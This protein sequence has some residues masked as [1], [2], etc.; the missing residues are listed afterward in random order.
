MRRIWSVVLSAVA[1]VLAGT[2]VGADGP[3]AAAADASRFAG[4]YFAPLNSVIWR[5]RLPDGRFQSFERLLNTPGSFRSPGGWQARQE[6][7]RIA[8]FAPE[9]P[10][11]PAARYEFDRGLLVRYVSAGVTNDFDRASWNWTLPAGLSPLLD[12]TEVKRTDPGEIEM[13]EERKW[14]KSGRLRF[15]YANPN[16]SGLLYA[17]L[18]LLAFGWAASRLRGR[19]IG[20]AAGAV[21]FGMLLATGSRGALLGFVV[22]LA[23]ML[24][25]RFKSSLRSRRFWL[26][27]AAVLCAAAA[28]L[29]V[30]R[31]RMLT[32][33]FGEGR[34]G[35]SNRIRL[36]L[37]SAAPKMM[38]DAPD[39]WGF[40]G[41]G[42]AYVNWYQPYEKVCFTGT[43]MN[44]HLN[45]LVEYGWTGRALYLWGGFALLCLLAFS[46]R[47]IGTVAPLSVWLAVATASWFNPVTR[48]VDAFIV[49]VLGL[50]PLAVRWRRWLSVWRVLAA[51]GAGAVLAGLALG[52]IVLL[53]S[54]AAAERPSVR[55][56]AGRVLLG[57]RAPE[58]WVVDD[59][60]ALGGILF[61]KDMRAMYRAND[62]LPPVG[63]VDDVATVPESAQRL[64]LAGGAGDDWLRRV[65][66]DEKARARLPR[67]VVFL[68]PPFP[69]S[70]VPPVLFKLCR[71][72]FVCGELAFRFEGYGAG[73]SPGVVVV[74]GAECY[75]PNWL[76]YVF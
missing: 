8:V 27:L 49:P 67:E 70:A 17:A 63:Y 59:G 43:L 65:C 16:Q 61:G 31:P 66:S 37:W 2:V 30:V 62:W 55:A 56:E 18:A 34:K 3:R 20:L 45:R 12:Y 39:G 9:T 72:R 74:P 5:M 54:R 6:G 42:P 51:V 75:L 24:A 21:C 14:K 28:G 11:D 7:A 53:G 50:L 22:G 68:S 58:T 64:V 69:L 29:A 15:P 33:G 46:A 71:V 48:G 44:D 26:I 23:P 38:V 10:E 40:C 35:W 36:E 4:V 19:L 76:G 13:A 52:G 57:G 47:R 1:C 41:A 25:V 73:R 32:R 60:R